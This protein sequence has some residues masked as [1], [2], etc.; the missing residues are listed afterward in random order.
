MVGK[1]DYSEQFGRQN[2]RIKPRGQTACLVI[3]QSQL[4]AIYTS[5]FSCRAAGLGSN[6]G[7]R[8]NDDVFMKIS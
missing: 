6:S 2:N 4:I 8:F 3:N 7:L 5:F 1:S